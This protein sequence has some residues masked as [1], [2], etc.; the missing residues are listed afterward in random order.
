MVTVTG[1]PDSAA[2]IEAPSACEIDSVPIVIE[3][4]V[5]VMFGGVPA[6]LLATITAIAPAFCAFCTAVVKLQLER[7]TSAIRPASAA[8]FVGAVQ[9]SFIGATASTASTTCAVTEYAWGPKFAVPT[10]RL[11]LSDPELTLIS[12]DAATGNTYICMRGVP[13]SCGVDM[14]ALPVPP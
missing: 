6:T 3:P 11:P 5:P 13:P 7:S 10:V 14:F 4:V 2:F 12:A 1:P 9:A 8:A